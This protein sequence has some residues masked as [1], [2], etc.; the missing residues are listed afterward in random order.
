MFVNKY[1]VKYFVNKIFC[2][3]FVNKYYVHVYINTHAHKYK[4][5]CFRQYGFFK[6]TQRF[7]EK[8]NNLFRI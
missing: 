2:K 6:R 5:G 1:Y 4:Y 7:S 8:E 3:Y